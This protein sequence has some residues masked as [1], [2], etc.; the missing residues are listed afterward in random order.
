MR[1]I[2]SCFTQSTNVNVNLI[3][4][5]LKINILASSGLVKLTHE[6]NHRTARGKKNI[7]LHTGKD[8]RITVDSLSET[9]QAEDN[10]L[11][12]PKF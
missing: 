1:P 3:P 7:L 9:M 2:H 10:R 6:I 5:T 8:L 11:T 12:S 4:E